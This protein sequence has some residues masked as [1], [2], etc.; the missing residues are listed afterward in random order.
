MRSASRDENCVDSMVLYFSCGTTRTICL[1]Y[2]F[3]PVSLT[4]QHISFKSSLK[5][6]P[7]FFVLSFFPRFYLNSIKCYEFLGNCTFSSWNNSSHSVSFALLN[8]FEVSK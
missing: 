6:S 1:F 4:A 8:L 3:I 7:F 5:L 2:L